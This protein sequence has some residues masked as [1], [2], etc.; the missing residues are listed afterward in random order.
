MLKKSIFLI[1]I[2]AL[3]S[4]LLFSQDKGKTNDKPSLKPMAKLNLTDEQKSKIEDFKLEM[5]KNQINE[6]A[7]IQTLEVEIKQVFSKDPVD[8]NE[9][10][11]KYEEIAKH[12]VTI[13]MNH[14]NFWKSVNDILKPDQQ[15]IWKEMAKNI[16][17][18]KDMMRGRN[19]DMGKMRN[20][21]GMKP[22]HRMNPPENNQ[23]MDATQ[24][25]KTK[26]EKKP[27]K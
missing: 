20:M 25:G 1:V 27:V 15:K 24:T 8:I 14:L 16:G 22:N 23:Q 10:K 6:R 18:G 7:K 17:R 19:G 9:V 11:T 3:S 13:K 26:A 4:V 5:Q 12:Q 2:F 21:R